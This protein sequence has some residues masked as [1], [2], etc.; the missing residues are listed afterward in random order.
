MKVAGIIQARMR[1]T[2]MPGK[3][4][5]H[6]SGR[7]ILGHTIDRLRNCPSV[8]DVA[9]VTS[10]ERDDDALEAFGMREGIPVFRGEEEDVLGR[11]MLAVEALDPDRVLRVT[12][13][14]PLLS[15]S[16]VESFLHQMSE[17]NADFMVADPGVA[18]IQEGVD[19]VSRLAFDLLVDTARHD[20]FAREHVT[21]YFKSHPNGVKIGRLEIPPE[22]QFSGVRISVDTPA[23]IQF[24]SELE[25]RLG[26]SWRDAA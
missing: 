11:Y 21:S 7:E 8:T 1:S 10:T 26:P 19:A 18:C 13:D 14:C 25:T 9:L 24:L 3:V 23:D 22:F 16:L 15:E 17:Q 5:R 12:G 2:R 20:P 4:L 6:L